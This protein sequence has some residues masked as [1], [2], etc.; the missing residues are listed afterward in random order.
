MV[1][2]WWITDP[3]IPIHTEPDSK[4]RGVRVNYQVDYGTP[5][6]D[7]T[8]VNLLL[9]ST[10]STLNENFM[11]IDVKDFYLNTP[12]ARSEYLRLKLSDLLER[13]VQNYN[14]EEKATR[15]GFIYI[16]IKRE[17]YGLPQAGLIAQQPMFM[18]VLKDIFSCWIFLDKQ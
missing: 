1:N 10:V 12:M 2:Q 3:K 6:V 9:D 15:D 18:I 7:L 14:L 13:V 16:Q 8:T 11:T 4:Q 17:M 5:T